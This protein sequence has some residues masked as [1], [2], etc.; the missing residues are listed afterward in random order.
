MDSISRF[1][2]SAGPQSIHVFVHPHRPPTPDPVTLRRRLL[3]APIPAPMATPAALAPPRTCTRITLAP[4]TLAPPR[5]CTRIW[6]CP[7]RPA[8]AI[9]LISPPR[10]CRPWRCSPSG[11]GRTSRELV[12]MKTSEA[13][14]ELDEDDNEEP[15]WL[16]PPPLQ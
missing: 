2:I 13:E 7:P 8:P 12:S 4:A 16:R 14:V 10:N 5:P 11:G 3:P 9:R 1:A 6:L 15:P